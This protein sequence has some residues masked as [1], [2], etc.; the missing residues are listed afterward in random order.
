MTCK[1]RAHVEQHGC[2]IVMNTILLHA[3]GLF[4]WV[5]SGKRGTRV[6]NYTFVFCQLWVY[7][8]IPGQIVRLWLCRTSYIYVHLPVDYVIV[9]IILC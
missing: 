1:E 7:I 6:Y 8:Y 5:V 9:Y 4:G 3:H 2:F